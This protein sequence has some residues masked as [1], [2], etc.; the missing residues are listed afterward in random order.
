MAKIDVKQLGK[1]G[2]KKNISVAT[3]EIYPALITDPRLATAG[4]LA[5]GDEVEIFEL[6]KG[7]VVTDCYLVVTNAPAGTAQQATIEVSVGGASLLAATALGGTTGVVGKIA[8]KTYL[9]TGGFV[10]AVVGAQ[11]F[12]SGA[13][14]VVIEYHDLERTNGELIS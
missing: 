10:K 9:Q 12:D 4:Q 13:V 2:R 5:V 3:C 11:A 1:N 14:T 6:P 7:C 8:K